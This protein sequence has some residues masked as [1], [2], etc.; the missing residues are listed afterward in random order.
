MSL[1]SNVSQIIGNHS[2]L[3]IED[4]SSTVGNGWIPIVEEA[5]K[6]LSELPSATPIIILQIKEK[7]GC[8]LI[9]FETE[10]LVRTQ[11]WNIVSAAESK[12][13]TVCEFCSEEGKLRTTY[14][15]GRGRSWIKT[16]CDK[17]NI[18]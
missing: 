2:N 7:F 13:S 14:Q 16:L 3:T 11:A 17:C 18:P 12:A 9:Y 4:K 6:K 15:D 1:Q 5:A 8:L 10:D